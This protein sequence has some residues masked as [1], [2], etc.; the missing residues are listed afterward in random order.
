MPPITGCD[1][2][3]RSECIGLIRQINSSSLPP[4][5]AI[6]LSS[7]T[8]RTDSIEQRKQTKIPSARATNANNHHKAPW[9]RNPLSSDKNLLASCRLLATPPQSCSILTFVDAIT[10]GTDPSFGPTSSR[11]E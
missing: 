8:V 1:R 7:Y 6:T 3:E 11:N 5:M 10:L 4:S 9:E 2:K